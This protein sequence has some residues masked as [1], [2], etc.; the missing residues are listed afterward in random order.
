MEE[1]KYINRQS[2]LITLLKF[3]N[4]DLYNLNIKIN[5]KYKID[6]SK[7][8]DYETNNYDFEIQKALNNILNKNIYELIEFISNKSNVL[9]KTIIDEVLNKNLSNMT[10]DELI[11][12]GMYYSGNG[13][14]EQVR[15]LP[16]YLSKSI[17]I[18][19]VN[20]RFTCNNKYEEDI[21][22]MCYEDIINDYENIIKDYLKL[23]K[24][25]I[26]IKSNF[27]NYYIVS[28]DRNRLRSRHG[29]YCCYENKLILNDLSSLYHELLHLLSSKY[30]EENKIA[31]TG[32]YTYYMDKPINE[33]DEIGV[34]INEGFTQYLAEKEFD[35]KN[36]NVYKTE[37]KYV[38]KLVNIIGINIMKKYYFDSDLN[39]L[40]EYIENKY[41]FPKTKFK[42]IVSYLDY[43]CC[44]EKI[45]IFGYPKDDQVNECLKQIEDID[46]KKIYFELENIIEE[47]SMN[48]YNNNYK[49]YYLKGN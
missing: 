24:K 29:E 31:I 27:K 6:K 11:I 17:L 2:S 39:G 5:Q 3:L 21:D 41:N 18:S 7:S 15:S 44:Y 25:I 9:S 35:D 40:M 45:K 36:I 8:N 28:T 30:D 13:M 48:V 38:K 19:E 22:I 42:R 43:I 26:K 10:I 47:L 14:I 33:I 16:K 34:G 20:E 12:L 23:F 46:I 32:F 37:K 4:I 1:Y 49:K